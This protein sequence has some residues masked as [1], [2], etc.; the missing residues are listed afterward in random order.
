MFSRSSQSSGQDRYKYLP[1]NNECSLKRIF[2]SQRD[3]RLDAIISAWRF[4]KR[5][6]REMPFQPNLQAWFGD[7]E[8][9]RVGWQTIYANHKR[10][11][12]H[13]IFI[14]SQI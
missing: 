10:I 4:L 8:V 12:T 14:D 13:D 2:K 1:K 6:Q 5:P 9:K 3:H 7:E 11:K